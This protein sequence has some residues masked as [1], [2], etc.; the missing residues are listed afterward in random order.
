MLLRRALW[1]KSPFLICYKHT[2]RKVVPYRYF[3]DF[4][5]T[6]N[7]QNKFGL[8]GSIYFA[9]YLIESSRSPKIWNYAGRQKTNMTYIFFQFIDDEDSTEKCGYE[10]HHYEH[11]EPFCC[12]MW[13]KIVFL[14]GFALSQFSIGSVVEKFGTWAILRFATKALIMS[15]MIASNAG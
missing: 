13:L 9:N 1:Y 7:F 8:D 3:P 4:P 15:G 2:L 5:H 14:S 6:L 12:M 11:E 10:S